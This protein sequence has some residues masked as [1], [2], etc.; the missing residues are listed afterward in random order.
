MQDVVGSC[1]DKTEKGSKYDHARFFELESEALQRPFF[2]VALIVV[3]SSVAWTFIMIIATLI[4]YFKC[5]LPL[6][7]LEQMHVL[8][9]I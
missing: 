6:S 3:A 5:K 8:H 9:C 2:A 7:G 1:C 4:S